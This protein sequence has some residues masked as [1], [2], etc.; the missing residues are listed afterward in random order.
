MFSCDGNEIVVLLIPCENRLQLLL[1]LRRRLL[2]TTT[3]PK[4]AAI[5]ATATATAAATTTVATAISSRY[6]RNAKSV[7]PKFQTS[8]QNWRCIN[9][10]HHA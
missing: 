9:E 8:S 10:I 4:T 6:C 2:L 5:T 3:M 7:D 1:L